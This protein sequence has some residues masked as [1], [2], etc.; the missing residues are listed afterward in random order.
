MSY[1]TVEKATEYARNLEV[2]YGK[3]SVM[4]PTQL[5]TYIA[6]ADTIINAHLSH[7]YFTPLKVI[8]RE[9]VTKYPDPIPFIATKIAAAMAVRSVYSR[10]D[11]QVSQNAD[12][13]LNDAIRELSRFSDGQFQGSNRLDGQTLKARNF[14]I[15]PYVAPLD[16][17]GPRMGQ[18]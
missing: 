2:S 15:N 14:F 7:A 4:S 11:A 5:E 6:D 1:T 12:A 9:G 18:Q 13:H 3:A 8:V 16:P 17:P 10:I